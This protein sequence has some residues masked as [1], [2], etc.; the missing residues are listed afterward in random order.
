MSQCTAP[1]VH[2]S[3][4]DS[5]RLPQE[6]WLK[7]NF[8]WTSSN[9]S[10]IYHLPTKSIQGSQLFLHEHDMKIFRM[11]L[12]LCGIRYYASFDRIPLFFQNKHV[13]LK[14]HEVK[15]FLN[16][17]SICVEF[18]CRFCFLENIITQAIIKP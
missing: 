14:L 13:E 4:I 18:Y 5:S 15:S 1:V 3:L 9:A 17:I 2:R 16:G 6:C 8:L 12:N 11:L 10:C 7:S